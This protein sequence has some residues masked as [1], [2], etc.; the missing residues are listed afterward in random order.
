MPDAKP[1]NKACCPGCDCPCCSCSCPYCTHAAF[2]KQLTD[3]GVSV[4]AAAKIA[5]DFVHGQC[6]LPAAKR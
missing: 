2:M 4:D 3:A 6:C 5:A 1:A